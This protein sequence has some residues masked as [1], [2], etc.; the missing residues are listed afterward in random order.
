[1]TKKSNPENFS[2]L[3]CWAAALALITI[4]AVCAAAW[5]L[6]AGT[7][8]ARE[9]GVIEN[10][11]VAL[12]CLTLLLSIV[13][14]IRAEAAQRLLFVWTGALALVAGARELDAHIWLN[15]DHLGRFGVR[16]RTRWWVDDSVP[17]WL[18]L[19][20]GLFFLILLWLVLYPPIKHMRVLF[21]GLRRGSRGVGLLVLAMGFLALGFVMDDLLRT[22]QALSV[23]T[24]QM[25]EETSEII[26]A[27]LFL[28]GVFFLRETGGKTAPERGD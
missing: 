18:K 25:I 7:D 13:L 27:V 26:G 20:W 10:G 2:R 4:L 22:S 3:L 14:A 9:N 5:L 28:F 19:G 1:M 24:R 23:G 8:L 12:W 21:S 15:P 6:P 16:Y 17:L 11:S